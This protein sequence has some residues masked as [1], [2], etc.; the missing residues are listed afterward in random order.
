MSDHE[1]EEVEGEELGDKLDEV[2]SNMLK[3]QPSSANF[4]KNS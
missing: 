2:W 4:V 3:E 1:G